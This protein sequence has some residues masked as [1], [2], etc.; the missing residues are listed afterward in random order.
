MISSPTLPHVITHSQDCRTSHVEIRVSCRYDY[1]IT[2]QY[3]GYYNIDTLHSFK[4]RSPSHLCD[5]GLPARHS[6]RI[7]TAHDTLR[8]Q[9]RSGRRWLWW[10]L[11]PPAGDSVDGRLDV[12]LRGVHGTLDV[13]LHGLLSSGQYALR[14]LYRST[15]RRLQRGNNTDSVSRS[16]GGASTCG[17]SGG[18]RS[19]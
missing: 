9:R 19:N 11:L 18:G 4:S 14:G 2:V 13:R 3:F 1:I 15:G 6:L 16:S 5:S 8:L 12:W 10:L 17:I 7:W